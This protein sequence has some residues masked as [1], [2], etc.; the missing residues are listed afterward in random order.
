MD[1]IGLWDFTSPK[2]FVAVKTHFGEDGT[3]GFIRPQA[4]GLWGAAI[5][6]RGGVPFLTE[7]ATLYRHRRHQAVEHL[8]LADEHGFTPATTGMPII[9]ADGLL[10][11]EEIRVPVPGKHFT[12]VGVAAL[13][14]KIQ[15]MLLISHFTGHIQAG[16]GA[17]LKNLGMGLASRR[18]KMIQH[19]TARP[20]IKVSRCVGCG[21]CLSTCPAEAIS[22]R[23][24]S[25]SPHRNTA[26]IARKTCIGCGECLAVCRFEA[27][28]YNWSE[29]YENLQEK[30][31]EYAMGAW[32]TV[33][34]RALACSYLVRMSPDCDCMA[35]RPPMTE[36]IGV[37]CSRDPVALD[38]ASLDLVEERLGHPLGKAA[39]DIPLYTQLAHAQDLG[40]GSRTYTLHHL[41]QP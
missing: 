14:G 8:M 25:E 28:G 33:S 29:T 27:I 26:H 39:H 31:A 4:L 1:R 15:S 32:R 30:M 34:P 24:A 37:L 36:D 7:T 35:T 20:S 19:S 21:A 16:F 41:E 6:Q 9:M 2:D 12:E 3:S 17:S 13:L 11:D 40:L 18:G 10:G 22:L 23:P 5:R 38:Q